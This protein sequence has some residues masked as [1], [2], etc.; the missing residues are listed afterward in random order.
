MGGV[1]LVR[2]ACYETYLSRRHLGTRHESTLRLDLRV[3][4]KDPRQHQCQRVVLRYQF[5]SLASAV[6]GQ[7]PHIHKDNIKFERLEV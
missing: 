3:A 4:V 7:L 2:L 6:Q 5:L 1:K